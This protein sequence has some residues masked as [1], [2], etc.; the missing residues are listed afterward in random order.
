MGG[1]WR[2]LTPKATSPDGL[3][4]LSV[5]VL[6][7]DET[8]RLAA[9]AA[10][11]GV[12]VIGLDRFTPPHDQGSSHGRSRIIREAYFE[13]PLYVPLV[14]RAYALWDALEARSRRTLFRRTGGLMMGP[15][16]GAVVAG[17]LASARA[18]DLP[19]E[20]LDAGPAGASMRG[21]RAP[22]DVTSRSPDDRHAVSASSRSDATSPRLIELASDFAPCAMS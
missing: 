18:H 11:R 4:A 2:S 16:D 1:R 21:H 14:Q 7:R 8:L 12:R 3:D 6:D 19:F 10:E 13:H 9:I 15:P 20:L 17:A 5:M 22:P